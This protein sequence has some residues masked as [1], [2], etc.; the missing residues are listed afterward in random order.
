MIDRH[1]APEEA[2]DEARPAGDQEGD[3][4]Q[5][6]GRHQLVPMQP[7]Q[8]RIL[9]EIA[10]LH[11]IDGVV[12]AGEDPAHMGEEK[13]VWRGECT[14]SSVSEYRWWCRCLAAHHS[15]LFWAVLW[16]RKARMNWNTRLVA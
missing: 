7:H 5:H 1:R 3:H 11:E 8:L 16:A 4:G 2:D 9:G 14:S 6:D 10:D 13:P 12:L 15:T